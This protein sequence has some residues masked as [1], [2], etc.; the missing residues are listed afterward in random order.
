MVV[1]IN[2]TVAQTLTQ[3]YRFSPQ[4][5][6]DALPDYDPPEVPKGAEVDDNSEAA[7]ASS[8]VTID[9]AAMEAAA[10]LASAKSPAT[11]P[12]KPPSE[13][14]QCDH[15]KVKTPI[16]D[17]VEN[18]NPNYMNEN[19]RL[20]DASCSGCKKKLTKEKNN[21]K[22]TLFDR[23]H[24]VH[25]CPFQQSRECDYLLCHA[26]FSSKLNEVDDNAGGRRSRAG[27]RS[28]TPVTSRAGTPVN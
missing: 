28:G 17:L 11:K 22:Q 27:S 23:K 16:T 10:T 20:H 1:S 26:C 14:E 8:N 7:M 15:E 24:P 4:L 3:W 9:T 19:Q 5:W 13:P 2:P 25:C 6:Q 21:D 12:P 18:D